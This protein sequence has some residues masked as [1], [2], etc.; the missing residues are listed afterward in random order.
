[1][2]ALKFTFNNILLPDSN[3]NEP[4][5][6]G[7]V[8]YRIHTRTGLPDNTIVNN[9]A[10]IVFDLNIPVVTN[11]SLNTMIYID[12]LPVELLYFRAGLDPSGIVLLTWATASEIN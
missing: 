9:T 7:E 2:G 4:M 5:S 12:P 10:F 3:I 11:T 1:N 8:T 6:H